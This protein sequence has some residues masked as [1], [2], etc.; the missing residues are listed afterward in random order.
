MFRS[1]NIDIS[2]SKTGRKENA[3][4]VIALTKLDSTSGWFQFLEK[5]HLPAPERQ[6]INNLKKSDFILQPGDAVIRRGGLSYLHTHGNGGKF[7]VL[8]YDVED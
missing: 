1:A 8:V 7:Q 4:V 3:F 5:S 6:S 2:L